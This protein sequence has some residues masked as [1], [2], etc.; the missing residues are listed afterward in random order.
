ML[1]KVPRVERPGR[2]A[3]GEPPHGKQCRA[4]P[5]TRRVRPAI[6]IGALIEDSQQKLTAEVAI[7]NE[8]EEVHE[9]PSIHNLWT[10]RFILSLLQDVG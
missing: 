4:T 9:L 6:G 5:L 7:Y 8:T 2:R 10:A 1:S 3:R